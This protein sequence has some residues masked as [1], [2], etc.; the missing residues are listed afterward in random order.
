MLNNDNRAALLEKEYHYLQ[1]VIEKFDDK[2]LQ[3]KGWSVT[4]CLAGAV[5]ATIAK[6]LG[7]DLR[8]VV[9]V[10]CCVGAASF[11]F[12]DASWKHF[13]KSYYPRIMAIEEAMLSDDDKIAPLQIT[14][15][16]PPYN[17]AAAFKSYCRCII[18]PNV[19]LP[20]LAIFLACL[21]LAISIV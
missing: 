6:D 18:M 13:Q 5:T 15:S 8:L 2:A 12:I 20:H 21:W 7:S 1:G 14:S 10:L 4:A 9:Y 17:A 3:I 16:W 11:W 19:F